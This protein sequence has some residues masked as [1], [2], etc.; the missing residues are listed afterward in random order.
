MVHYQLGDIFH[1]LLQAGAWWYILSAWRYISRTPLLELD[2]TFYQLGD[3]FHALPQAGAWWYITSLAIYFTHSS[4]L[5]L[6]D[7]FIMTLLSENLDYAFGWM[8]IHSLWQAT[9]IALISGIVLILLR[10]KSAKLKYIL[11]NIA[12]CTVLLTAVATFSWYYHSVNR[13][14]LIDLSETI[15]NSTI[16]KGNKDL[17]VAEITPSPV[18][19]TVRTW[20]VANFRDYF[21]R[22][23]PLVV[24]VWLLGVTVFVLRLL[25]GISY[26]YY[27][28]TRMNFPPDEYWLELLQGLLKRTSIRKTVELVESAL[29]RTPMVVGYL[30]PLILFPLGAINRLS[31]QEVEAILAHELAHI[32][33]H[34]YLF[35]ILQS[36]V[37]ALFYYHPA[38]W[39]MSAQIRDE[40]ESACDEIAIDLLG[41]SMK[42]A[43]ALVIIQELAYFPFSPSLA[44]AGQNKS[45]FLMRMQ[46]I[47]NQPQNKSNIMEKLIATLLVLFTLIG[48]N[49][50]Q[51]DS[52]KYA[53][54]KISE[55]ATIFTGDGN[56]PMKAS[57]FW[58]AL[59]E[60]DEVCVTFNNSQKNNN[61][62]TN[63]CFSKKEFSTLPTQDAEFTLQREA[64]TVTFKGKF[65]GNE[66]YG[67]QSFVANEAFKKM[68]QEKGLDTRGE[69]LAFHA[70]LANVNATYFEELKNLGLNPL[71]SNEVQ[72]FL[73]HRITAQNIKDYISAFKSSNYTP[74]ADEIIA[75]KL[76]G[77]DVAY[78]QKMNSA[79][80][81]ILSPEDVLACKIHNLQ[82]EK[83][84]ELGKLVNEKM[85][86]DDQLAFAIHGID[87]AFIKEIQGMT[88][89]K[90]SNDDIIGAKIQGI[91][92]DFIQP[93]YSAGLAKNT[94]FDELIALKIH[95][96]E[97]SD[98]KAFT[99]VGL[100]N[101]DAGKLAELKIAMVTPDFIVE[102]RK[103][104][105]QSTEASTYID[106][107]YHNF[108]R[109]ANDNINIDIKDDG[110]SVRGE[111]VGH[112]FE[113]GKDTWFNGEYKIIEEN[114]KITKA[115]QDGKLMN[116]QQLKANL[117]L[118]QKQID[119]VKADV[120]RGKKEA[121]EAQI[122]AK[123]A[124]E[125][126]KQAQIEA[127]QAQKEERLAQK[128]EIQAQKE[129]R[130][131]Q[132]DALKSQRDYQEGEIAMAFFKQ[133]VK[134]GLVQVNK[135]YEISIDQN[136]L[137]INGKEIAP[138]VYNRYKATIVQSITNPKDKN[139]FNFYL[140]G[141]INGIENDR[142]SMTGRFSVNVGE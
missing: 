119:E 38:V 110:Y 28:R 98:V 3:I 69:E 90:L 34:D 77:I 103:K 135:K 126:A 53:Y 73:I 117:N 6:G 21:D 33:R 81:N 112:L 11:A 109:D 58:N 61:W 118:L 134:D 80:D 55:N 86:H 88:S 83:M 40:R 7:T 16:A 100:R 76:Q 39:W 49:I 15:T 107:K 70:F 104:G 124:R 96:V 56:M 93:F 105:V 127:I 68:L 18:S 87:A 114:G 51:N 63:E 29:V 50:A 142:I 115:Y 47:L 101:L 8:V 85:T 95:G 4:K 25:G 130:L 132:L 64:G 42:Y 128:E 122:E 24:L 20:S 84:A 27:L 35:N 10:K 141:T 82:P 71:Q 129:A 137:K 121:A 102:A 72:A 111:N 123:Q 19:P 23:L 37:E 139:N 32:M 41:N 14:K 133:L 22:N 54:T 67:K 92:A 136:R 57:G 5:E 31:E 116:K 59:V 78:I 106:L 12:L 1:A 26:I 2:G 97:P 13:T 65:E 140:K 62:I 89:K 43:K 30:K 36:L 45:Q 52:P 91:N 48:L 75:M 125:E 46:R 79:N 60:N 138:E 99:N 120:D 44:F 113:D 131:A 94:D 17:A 9:L 66:G 108:V 74:S